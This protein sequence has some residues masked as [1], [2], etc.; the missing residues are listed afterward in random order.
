MSFEAPKDVED[1]LAFLDRNGFVVCSWAGVACIS[2][3]RGDAPFARMS[4]LCHRRPLCAACHSSHL[5]SVANLW[6]APA[7]SVRGAA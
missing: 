5:R 2:E 6:S 4:C 1:V 3:E 7:Y